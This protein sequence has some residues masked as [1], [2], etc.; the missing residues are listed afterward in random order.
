M[1]NQTMSMG[2]ILVVKM[3]HPIFGTEVVWKSPSIPKTPRG[4]RFLKIGE[5]VLPTDLLP[6]GRLWG[7]AAT[8][9][10]VKIKA[11]LRPYIRR[12]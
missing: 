10:H 1:K 3:M 11:L 4:Y 9:K 2:A 5:K 8:R 7:M 6:C 12:K